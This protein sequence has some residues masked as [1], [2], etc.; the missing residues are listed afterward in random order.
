MTSLKMGPNFEQFMTK[1]LQQAK[2]LWVTK[3]LLASQLSLSLGL[4][5]K[6]LKIRTDDGHA[7]VRELGS[8]SILSFLL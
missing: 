8:I 7:Q 2:K 6:P 3:L 5:H 4:S 1:I